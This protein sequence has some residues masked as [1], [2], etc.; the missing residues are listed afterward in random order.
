ML[1]Y[2]NM[3]D[4]TI[5]EKIKNLEEWNVER[6][7]I[8]PFLDI[9]LDCH[10]KARREAYW[11]NYEKAQEFFKQAIENYK[12]TLKLNP[13][14]YLQDIVER[15]DSVLEEHINNIFNLKSGGDALKTESGIRGF[16]EFIENLKPEEKK[17]I[18][19][20]EIALS[21]LKIADLYYEEG[22]IDSSYE[23]YNRVAAMGC[24][25]PFLN[26]DAY[27]NMGKILFNKKRFK[28]ALVNFVSVLS[29]D[30]ANKEAISYLDK[31]L[32]ELRISE[33][34]LKFLSAT[35]NEA[36]KL[37]MEVL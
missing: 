9:A 28:E 26:V 6:A 15:V 30:K 37:I 20:Y 3:E 25:R 32:N 29:F 5:E 27:F 1:Y 34:R 13:K 22:R 24:D 36:K 4:N 17:Y 2:A 10:N 8:K 11:K 19:Q 18:D 12:A 35:P 31:C 23:F 33:H 16:V 14:Y 21:Y 7:R